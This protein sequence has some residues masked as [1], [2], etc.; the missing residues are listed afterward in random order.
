MWIS[1]WNI[2]ETWLCGSP[3][4]SVLPIL[5]LCVGTCPNYTSLIWQFCNE[6]LE[7]WRDW[8][9]LKY[10]GVIWN[11]RY[12][13]CMMYF[14]SSSSSRALHNFVSYRSLEILDIAYWT[15]LRVTS[16][17]FNVV[18]EMRSLGDTLG[19]LMLDSSVRKRW[20]CDT[21]FWPTDYNRQWFI[22]TNLAQFSRLETGQC[23]CSCIKSS[24]CKN[25]ASIKN[26]TIKQ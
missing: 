7:S 9:A 16:T 11:R 8:R 5:L 22:N 14:Q 12:S 20:G 1:S 17:Y 3:C 23:V 4:I 19:K 6:L 13:W 26:G 2:P 15:M 24:F 25:V 10:S 21:V 18:E